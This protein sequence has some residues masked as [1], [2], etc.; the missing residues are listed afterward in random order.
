M[1]TI[2]IYTICVRYLLKL[3]TFLFRFGVPEQQAA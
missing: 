3:L 2:Y 1:Y